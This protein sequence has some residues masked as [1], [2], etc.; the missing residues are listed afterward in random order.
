MI[1][2]LS[3]KLLQKRPQGPIVEVGGVGYE[4]HLSDEDQMRLPSPG[5]LIF[6]WTHLHIKET[7]WLLFGFFS[8]Q[9]RDFF[10]HLLGVNG[11][12][13]KLALSCIGALEPAELIQ[14]VLSQS[15][16]KLQNVPGIGKKL[17][18]RL[19]IELGSIV[20][21]IGSIPSRI[22][23]A[24]PISPPE[25]SSVESHLWSEALQALRQ[26]GYKD[27]CLLR[28]IYTEV[29]AKVRPEGISSLLKEMLKRCDVRRGEETREDE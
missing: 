20:K 4:V 26:L 23:K 18:A 25:N 2:S 27:E 6:L 13:P 24:L 14:I 16:E 15:P 3:G 11:M 21:K 5:G 8:M 7:Q 19:L 28:S 9:K 12:G 1:G 10:R 17:A 22:P 29:M